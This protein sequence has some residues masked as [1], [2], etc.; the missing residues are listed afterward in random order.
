MKRSITTQSKP[1]SSICSRLALRQLCCHPQLAD[2]TKHALVN[3]K[4]LKDIEAIMLTHY[5]Q[6]VV[7]HRQLLQSL[8]KHDFLDHLDKQASHPCSVIGEIIHHVQIPQ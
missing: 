6:E 3:C 5:K 2:E 1:V 8:C 4:S 7:I